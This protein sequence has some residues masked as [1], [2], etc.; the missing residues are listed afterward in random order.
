MVVMHHTLGEQLPT[1]VQLVEKMAN[2]L[3]INLTL[4]SN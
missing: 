3:L 4:Q 2:N 1:T